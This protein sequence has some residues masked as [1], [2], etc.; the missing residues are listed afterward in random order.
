MLNES[1]QRHIAT[2]PIIVRSALPTNHNETVV[3]RQGL[4]GMNHNETVVIRRGTVF[5]NHNETVVIR[6]GVNLGNHNETVVT[7][8]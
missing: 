5:P 4:N 3:I 2:V 8:R 6:N 7:G 1:Q